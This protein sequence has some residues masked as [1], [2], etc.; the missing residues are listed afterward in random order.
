[1]TA[2]QI[3]ANRWNY[4]NVLRED[5][6]SCGDYGEQLTYLLSLKMAHERTQAAWSQP[7]LDPELLARDKASLG[8]FWP[9]DD[10]LEASAKLLEPE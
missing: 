3:V 2:Q 1:M 10:T 4:D 5:G 9:K 8:V 6:L 7:F